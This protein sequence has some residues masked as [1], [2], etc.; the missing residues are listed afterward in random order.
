MKTEL[1]LILKTKMTKF[2]ADNYNIWSFTLK[3]LMSQTML[4]FHLEIM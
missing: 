1:I 3:I 2:G 4:L